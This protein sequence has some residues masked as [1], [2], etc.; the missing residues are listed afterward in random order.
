VPTAVPEFESPA[1][2][3][4]DLARFEVR[5]SRTSPQHERTARRATLA[6]TLVGA[7]L[8]AI[9][10]FDHW[11]A[12]RQQRPVSHCTP[13][14]RGPHR[15]AARCSARTRVFGAALLPAATGPGT[16][17]PRGRF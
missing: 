15:T 10:A 12:A 2:D 9:A 6:F 14:A 3:D 13:Y 17:T 4:D 7:L 1:T 5:L 8:A 16:A 11:D